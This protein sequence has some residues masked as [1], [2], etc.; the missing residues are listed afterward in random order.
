MAITIQSI[1]MLSKSLWHT[2]LFGEVM[3]YEDTC[4]CNANSKRIQKMIT[5]EE[6]DKYI[7]ELTQIINNKKL[8]LKADCTIN[9]LSLASEIPRRMI[10]KVINFRLQKSFPEYMNEYRIQ[11]AKDF[12]T[13]KS[14]KSLTY[15]TIALECGFGSKS[16][17]NKIF[18]KS[19][20]LT[21][22]Q[23]QKRFKK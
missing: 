4:G 8:Y 22:S 5:D 1:L 10:S 9:D 6:A 16:N 15:E 14:F 17:F 3:D 21:P 20:N 12:L 18:K 7:A 13:N 23:Y 2:R 11:N 19:T